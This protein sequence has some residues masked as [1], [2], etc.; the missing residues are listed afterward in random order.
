[1]FLDPMSVKLRLY[2][3]DQYSFEGKVYIYWGSSWTCD[4]LKR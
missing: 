1:M 2:L 3:L 4:L